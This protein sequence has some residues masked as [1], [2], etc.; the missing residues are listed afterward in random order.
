MSSIAF[1]TGI[2]GQDG[3][4]LSE[5]LL[6]KGY[7]VYGIVR[8]NSMVF[9]YTRLEHIKEKL[10]LRYGDL[11]DGSSLNA[12][13]NEIV[14]TN[15]GFERLEVYNLG[16][17]SHVQ[18]SFE[19]PD[20]TSQVDALGTL[21]LLESIRAL[22]PDIRKKIRFYQ[23]GT[24]EMFGKVL[25]TPQRETTPFNP[26]S[27]YACAKVYSHFLVKN[28]REGYDLFACNG[29]G[30][31]HESPRRGDNF[32]T[33]KIVNAVK[34]FQELKE[35]AP[36]Q[37]LTTDF[38]LSLGN[39][40]SKRDWGHAKD[41]VKGMWLMLQHAKP[42]DYVL[43]TGETHTVKDFIER[44]FHKIGIAIKWTGVDIDEHGYD[45]ITGKI[46]V[47]IDEKYF[48]PCEVDIL[49]GDPTKIE[50]VLGW[51]REYDTLDRLI[52]SMF[53]EK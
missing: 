34:K 27:P 39:I 6:E 21:K 9:N 3:S 48:R 53:Y 45:P 17:Q 51:R 1:I 18:I 5:L 49:L 7:K 32:V 2:T 42:D 4:Y 11:T 43:A 26:Q 30:N 44:C 23:A 15:P 47:K 37:Y 22:A 10:H 16:A 24:S 19:N 33:K 29:I 41:Y 14:S 36:N 50:T 35:K 46:L 38:V 31:N 25:E 12:I 13:I 8:R 28:Y 52:D 20:Y 40:Y